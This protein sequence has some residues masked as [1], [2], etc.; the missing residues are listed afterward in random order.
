MNDQ[1]LKCI[2]TLAER[3]LVAGAEVHRV[4]ECVGRIL[5]AP[6][7]SCPPAVPP[8]ICGQRVSQEAVEVFRYYGIGALRV[9]KE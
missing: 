4:E 5:A 2:I 6:S 1:L 7:V 8:L 9:I 3:M